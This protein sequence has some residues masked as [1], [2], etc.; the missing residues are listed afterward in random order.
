M[1]AASGV[2]I[3]ESTVIGGDVGVTS[4]L[5]AAISEERSLPG[6]DVDRRGFK[7]RGRRFVGKGST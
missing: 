5:D 7:E 1:V 2:S 4:T 6:M 3:T